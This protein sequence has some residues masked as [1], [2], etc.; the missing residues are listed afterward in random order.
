MKTAPAMN[1]DRQEE[2]GIECRICWYRY[3]PGTGDPAGGIPPG[4]AVRDL[5][6]GWRCPVCD[7]GREGFLPVSGDSR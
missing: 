2:A 5:P 7:G 3:D 4:T 6:D 1:R